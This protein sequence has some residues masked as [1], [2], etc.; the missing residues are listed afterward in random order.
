MAYNYYT[1]N[2]IINHDTTIVADKKLS[3][4]LLYW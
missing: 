3:N 4:I 1:I 2:Y